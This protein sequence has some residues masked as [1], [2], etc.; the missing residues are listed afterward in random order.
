[1]K[2]NLQNNVKALTLLKS[3]LDIAQRL[4]SKDLS[5]IKYHPLA[6][7]DMITNLD[8]DCTYEEFITCLKS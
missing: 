5:D 7:A 2:N 4:A 3:V 1:M 6:I 8:E